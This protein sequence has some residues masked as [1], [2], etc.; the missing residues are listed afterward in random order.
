VTAAP[1]H[2][3]HLGV[4]YRN[5]E[6]LRDVTLTVQPGKVTGMIGP[7]GAGKSTLLKAMLG[8]IPVS[9]GSVL[10][11]NQPLQQSLNQVAYVPQ[12]SQ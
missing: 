1:I 4:F 12:R 6:A 10:Y 5:V 2:V 9:G 11:Q 7:N 8:L 3:N